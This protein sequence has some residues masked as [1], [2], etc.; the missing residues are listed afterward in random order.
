MKSLRPGAIAR[1]CVCAFIALVLTACASAPPRQTYNREANSAIKSISVLPM[2]ESKPTVMM[3]NHPGAQFG[4]IGALVMA[5]NMSGK[6]DKLERHLAEAKFDQNQILRQALA[7]ALEKRGYSVV[8]PAELVEAGSKKAQR[9]K[10]G[11]R[12][13]YAPTSDAQAQLDV[14]FGFIGYA[15]AGASDKQPYRPTATM[16][17]RL[18]SA[19]GKTF[20]FRDS[21]AYNN[22]FNQNHAIV[23][24]P[25]EQFTYPDFDDLDAAGAQSADGLRLAIESL[26][27]KIA[28]QL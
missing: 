3:M 21:F 5:G 14:N 17:A 27:D 8:W 9:D 25:G 24:E 16:V 19:D 6:E 4:L 20:Y 10:F 23:V 1:L 11:L 15:A 26:A 2:R 12:K 22:V 28:E 18:I 13:T 7:A